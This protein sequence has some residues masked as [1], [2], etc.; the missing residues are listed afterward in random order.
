MLWQGADDDEFFVFI[1]QEV[2]SKQV[3]RCVANPKVE[4]QKAVNGFSGV[5]E[6]ILDFVFFRGLR[7]GDKP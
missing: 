4:I 1:V 7:G 3:L 5:T 2:Y 6:V